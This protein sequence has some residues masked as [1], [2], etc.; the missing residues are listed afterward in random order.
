MDY[1]R[2]KEM[3]ELAK[4]LVNGAVIRLNGTPTN[5]NEISRWEFKVFDENG[6]AYLNI[7]EKGNTIIGYEIVEKE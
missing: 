5:F 1:K 6:E 4:N 3:E 7:Y 2:V